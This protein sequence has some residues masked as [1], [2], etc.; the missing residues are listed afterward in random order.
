MLSLRPLQWIND[1]CRKALKLW[2][3]YREL[4]FKK[5][6]AV[7]IIRQIDNN[8]YE[9][10][11]RGRVGIFPI[12]YVEVNVQQ[13]RKLVCLSCM[14][15][16]CTFCIHTITQCSHTHR[17]CRPQRNRSQFVLHLQHMSER[18]ERQWHAT[19]SMLIQMWSCLSER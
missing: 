5:G 6:D 18:L 17:R 19:T 3:H 8:W 12:S 15:V 4:T 13:I 14:C 7:N 10:E 11:H 2:L 16:K 9:G 1:A